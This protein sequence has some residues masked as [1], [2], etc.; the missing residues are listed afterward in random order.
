MSVLTSL[1]FS[2]FFLFMNRHRLMGKTIVGIGC[3]KTQRLQAWCWEGQSW[4]QVHTLSYAAG[5]TLKC[6]AVPPVPPCGVQGGFG[7]YS[8][9]SVTSH[10]SSLQEIHTHAVVMHRYAQPSPLW[11]RSYHCKHT[12]RQLQAPLYRDQNWNKQEWFDQWETHQL[13]P[14]LSRGLLPTSL[15]S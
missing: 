15:Q 11:G 1:Y 8:W 9:D 2:A 13:L 12:G 7:E 10:S 6:S 14:I 4:V 5:S 3:C